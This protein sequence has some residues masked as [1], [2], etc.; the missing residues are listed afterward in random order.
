MKYSPN[1]KILPK[2]FSNPK[3]ATSLFN[4]KQYFNLTYCHF[5]VKYWKKML[6]HQQLGVHNTMEHYLV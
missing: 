6:D 4:G 5:V 1:V 3:I 2:N